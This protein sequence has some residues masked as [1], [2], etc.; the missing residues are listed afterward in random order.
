MQWHTATRY[1]VLTPRHTGSSRPHASVACGQRILKC[2]SRS[3]NS[4]I[5]TGYSSP[6]DISVRTRGYSSGGVRARVALFVPVT[7]QTANNLV[8]LV[9]DTRIHERVE[10][11]YDQVGCDDEEAREEHCPHDHGYVLVLDCLPGLDTDAGPPKDLLDDQEP[12]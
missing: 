2:V 7:R 8:L 1:S 4:S 5:T 10:Q 9:R 11:I 3:F 6:S 12:A